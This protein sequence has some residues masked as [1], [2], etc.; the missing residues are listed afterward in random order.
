M[1]EYVSPFTTL[2]TEKITLPETVPSPNKVIAAFKEVGMPKQLLTLPPKEIPL[3]ETD[4]IA[5]RDRVIDLAI[6]NQHPALKNRVAAI[7]E[8][9]A[10][11]DQ[12]TGEEPATLVENVRT[13]IAV[14]RILDLCLEAPTAVE[15][16]Q[17]YWKAASAKT[18]EQVEAI[19][20]QIAQVR[21]DPDYVSAQGN[22]ATLQTQMSEAQAKVAQLEASEALNKQVEETAEAELIKKTTGILTNKRYAETTF[23]PAVKIE[24]ADRIAQILSRRT[25]LDYVSVDKVGVVDLNYLVNTHSVL[26]KAYAA[27]VGQPNSSQTLTPADYYRLP[28]T[29]F[30]SEPSLEGNQ[31]LRYGIALQALDRIRQIYDERRKT[32]PTIVAKSLEN[33]RTNYR[34]DVDMFNKSTIYPAKA[35]EAALFIVDLAALDLATSPKEFAAIMD[36]VN[37]SAEGSL[38]PMTVAQALV[39]AGNNEYIDAQTELVNLDASRYKS[40]YITNKIGEKQKEVEER[41]TTLGL[42][43]LLNTQQSTENEAQQMDSIAARATFDRLVV[44]TLF[45]EITDPDQIS[46]LME[47]IRN[48]SNVKSLAEI[49]KEYRISQEGLDLQNRIERLINAPVANEQI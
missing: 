24:A 1:T 3:A 41:E 30:T 17:Q 26:V 16:I 8:T 15:K 48:K 39:K 13:C 43:T 37:R 20:A 44:A 5:R 22:L 38:S 49:L 25:P 45:P 42:P 46:R 35:A 9:K 18:R 14:N 19:K 32:P 2:P 27:A 33:M 29:Q 31:H 36:D 47:L 34:G 4:R 23:I 10:R 11:I 21:Q 40:T 28:H 12:L 7:A 6:G